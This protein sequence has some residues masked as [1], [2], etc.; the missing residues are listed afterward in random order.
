V[1]DPGGAAV[2]ELNAFEGPLF[3]SHDCHDLVGRD[4]RHFLYHLADEDSLPGIS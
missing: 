2:A 3:E 1:L 4:T